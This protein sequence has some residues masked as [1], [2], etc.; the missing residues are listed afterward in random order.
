STW[1]RGTRYWASLVENAPRLDLGGQA[2][3]TVTATQA[4][5]Q[6]SRQRVQDRK[7]R[8]KLKTHVPAPV[9]S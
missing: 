4:K 9:E 1:C 2:V 3:G 5:Q 6:A 7:N 8:A